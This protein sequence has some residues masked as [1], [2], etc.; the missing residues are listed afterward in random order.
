MPVKGSERL[1]GFSI[2]KILGR[3][4][5]MV[6][7]STPCL[8]WESYGG[9]VSPWTLEEDGLGRKMSDAAGQVLFCLFER[10]VDVAQR[11]FC[12]L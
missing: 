9:F 12:L 3:P 4:Q 1:V 6:C 8:I 10:M 2:L 11:P 7:P 5:V